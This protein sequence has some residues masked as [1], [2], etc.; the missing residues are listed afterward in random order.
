MSS[1]INTHVLFLTV[2]ISYCIIVY[3]YNLCIVLDI[4]IDHQTID[5]KTKYL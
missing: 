4:H 2:D 1:T 5:E 3:A